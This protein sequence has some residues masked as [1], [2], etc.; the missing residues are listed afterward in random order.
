[1]KLT[2]PRYNRRLLITALEEFAGKSG[3]QL[4]TFVQAEPGV[5]AETVTG[6]ETL[7]THIV[8]TAASGQ[9]P[10]FGLLP[11]LA[12]TADSPRDDFRWRMLSQAES[13]LAELG[14]LG[15][16]ELPRPAGSRLTTVQYVSGESVPPLMRLNRALS[17]IAWAYIQPSADAATEF[18]LEIGWE[19][20]DS[21]PYDV[22]ITVLRGREGGQ[23]AAWVMHNMQMAVVRGASSERTSFTEHRDW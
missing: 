10:D 11:R 8:L 5:S 6:V 2:R 20:F 12:L 3:K 13:N 16:A 17:G 4:E 21:D 14:S 9:E 7:L 22:V 23:P 18:H 15:L 19:P 1:M